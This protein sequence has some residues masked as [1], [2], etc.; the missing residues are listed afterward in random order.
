MKSL[1]YLSLVSALSVR[2]VPLLDP[3]DDRTTKDDSAH[4]QVGV[5]ARN[6]TI[7]ILLSLAC[8]GLLA[9]LLGTHEFPTPRFETDL[10]IQDLVSAD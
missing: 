3:R 2:A 9:F 7:F 4:L 10:F 8:M 1:A 6:R 5:P